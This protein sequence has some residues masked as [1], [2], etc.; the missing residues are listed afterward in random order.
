MGIFIAR[1]QEEVFIVASFIVVE[2]IVPK[3]ILPLL[4]G[5]VVLLIVQI[6]VALEP[7]LIATL[8][9]VASAFAA[10]GPL[11]V[12]LLVESGTAELVLIVHDLPHLVITPRS[13]HVR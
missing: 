4:P 11:H 3:R 2:L 9:L 12:H 7:R 8:V 1:P 5:D 6:F 13:V 10:L